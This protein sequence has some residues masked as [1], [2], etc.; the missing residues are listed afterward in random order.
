[1]IQNFD[2]N[3]R[4]NVFEINSSGK[5]FKI[6]EIHQNRFYDLDRNG[7][8]FDS[9]IP[10]RNE[11]VFWNQFNSVLVEKVS[12]PLGGYEPIAWIAYW[13]ILLGVTI[14]LV[15]IAE[16]ISGK[17]FWIVVSAIHFGITWKFRYS[18]FVV[19][20]MAGISIVVLIIVFATGSYSKKN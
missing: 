10:F 17:I 1:M 12:L 14:L 16:E 9:G 11:P 19:Y 4:Y 6:G 20:W 3:S 5:K 2:T 7:K 18:K 8:R 15:M 13:V